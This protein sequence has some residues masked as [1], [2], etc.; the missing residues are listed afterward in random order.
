VSSA[1]LI[2]SGALAALLALGEVAVRRTRIA[3]QPLYRRDRRYGYAPL[4]GS[5]GRAA[6]RFR[7]AHNRWGLRLDHDRLPGRDAVL[8]VGDSIVHGGGRVDQDDTLGVRLAAAAGVEVFPVAAPGWSLANALAYLA[9]TPELLTAGRIVVMVNTGDLDRLELWSSAAEHPLRIRS[10]LLYA[11]RKGMQRLRARL[12]REP[13]GRGM[14]VTSA[15]LR[16]EVE[17]L[18][19]RVAGE[20]LFAWYPRR[21]ELAEPGPA[22]SRVAEVL[23]DEM[24]LLDV[25]CFP[26]WDAAS[27]ADG[28]HPNALGRQRLARGLAACLARTGS[29]APCPTSI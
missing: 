6:G 13:S 3:E 23:P 18:R 2:A 14:P 28:I 25:S 29:R 22:R 19:E 7:W 16:K 9:A 21:E 1:A 20:L 17:T 4:P 24:P 15:D 12:G 10:H 11:A 8:L 27:Y 5:A 26:D